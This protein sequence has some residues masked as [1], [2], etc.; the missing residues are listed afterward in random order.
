MDHKRQGKSVANSNPVAEGHVRSDPI[1]VE[2]INVP[3]IINL[4]Q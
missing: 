1:N 2:E 3:E 4:W